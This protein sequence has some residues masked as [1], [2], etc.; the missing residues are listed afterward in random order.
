MRV[1]G[2]TLK[3]RR[4]R[5]PRGSAV[6]PTAD[7]VREAIFDILGP[8]WRYRRALD[9]FA[10]TGALGIEAL[11]RGTEHAVF[12]EQSRGALPVLRANLADLQLTMRARI[13]PVSI[14]KG[15]DLLARMHESF[16][17]IFMD[18][19]YGKGLVG[20]TLTLIGEGKLLAPD[21]IIVA[22]HDP[23]ESVVTAGLAC[24]KERRYGDTAISIYRPFS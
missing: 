7:R 24:E 6:R 1:I 3:S 13:L 11:S 20:P 4:L 8:R 17:L 15:I 23:G 10:G 12:I 16:D 14:K 21:G 18:P 5:V 9:L 22:E 2:G 19:P